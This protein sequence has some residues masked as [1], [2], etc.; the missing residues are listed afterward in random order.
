MML[1]SV[2]VHVFIML[3]TILA[4]VVYDSVL[5]RLLKPLAFADLIV[6]I[7]SVVAAFVVRYWL[8]NHFTRL[9]ETKI[10]DTYTNDETDRL[11]YAEFGQEYEDWKP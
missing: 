9:Q 1:L 3:I 5:F 7:L 4:I 2:R 8:I 11:L 10:A 6:L